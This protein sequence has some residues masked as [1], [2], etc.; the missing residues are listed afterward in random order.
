M[1]GGKDEDLELAH[2][3][4][5]MLRHRL[6]RPLPWRR[7]SWTNRVSS[8]HFHNKYLTGFL[9]G[10]ILRSVPTE[11]MDRYKTRFLLI[12]RITPTQLFRTTMF[13]LRIFRFVTFCIT[14]GSGGFGDKLTVLALL[15]P[16]FFVLLKLTII[17]LETN[18]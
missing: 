10:R 16:R 15:L 12:Y 14:A 1:N 18:K 4:C 2:R 6:L 11:L 17:I 13:Y 9:F 7:P 3:G 5:L 8:I